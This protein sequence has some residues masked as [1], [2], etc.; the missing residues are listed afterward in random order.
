MKG[1]EKMPDVLILNKIYM[2]RDQKVMVD[3][4]LAELYG[5]ETKVLKQAVRRNLKRF[6]PDFMF[7]MTPG[8]FKKWRSQFVT[9]ISDNSADKMGLR[10][11]P[12][13]F[14]ELGVTML[15]CIL[16]TERAVEVN[17]RVVRLFA[18]MR[19]VLSS[20]KELLSRI[21]R[22]ESAHGK[23]QLNIKQIFDALKQL[24]HSEATGSRKKIG[25]RRSNER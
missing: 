2:F 16:K 15:S 23:Q 8:E 9:S 21:E 6:P 14:T 11:A 19:E 18:K 22:L 1:V 17:I 24:I 25:Y 4:D 20:Q 10:Y 13:C 7:V 5:I 12:F 3:R